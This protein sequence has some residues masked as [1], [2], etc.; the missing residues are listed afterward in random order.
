MNWKLSRELR[1]RGILVT[2]V[3]ELGFAG[4]GI[5]DS[6]LMKKLVPHEPFVLIAWDNKMPYS[7]RFDLDHH[8]TT[9]AVID[10]NATRGGLDDEQYYRDVIHRHA[11]RMATQ[12]A[13]SLFKYNRTRRSDVR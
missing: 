11:H 6:A 4:K 7:H 8:G 1:R 13:G 9:L 3:Y 12:G 10:K 2:S 5:K